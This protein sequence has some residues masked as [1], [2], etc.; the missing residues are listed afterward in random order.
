[1]NL[2]DRIH[3]L[4]RCRRERSAPENNPGRPDMVMGSEVN[5]FG[6]ANLLIDQYGV[7]AKAEATRLMQEAMREDDPEAV[8]DWLTVEQAIV[9][10]TDDSP[11]TRN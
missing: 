4:F 5:Y 1:M 3:R 8:T 10:L 6:L 11:A 9:L 7:D 2:S